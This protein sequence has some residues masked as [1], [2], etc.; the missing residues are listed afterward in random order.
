[1]AILIGVFAPRQELAVAFPQ[2]H[3]RFPAEGLACV[4]LRF[5]PQL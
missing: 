4:R 1:M 5:E 2:P 3:L